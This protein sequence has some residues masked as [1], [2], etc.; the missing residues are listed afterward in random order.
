MIRRMNNIYYAID[1]FL[2]ASGLAPES[3]R[4]YRDILWKFAAQVD[5]LELD[6]VE[7]HHLNAF[8]AE[9]ATLS[10]STQ[11]LVVTVLKRFWE[12]LVDENIVEVSPAARLK[13]PRRP[14]PED[15]D[16]VTVSDSDVEKLIAACTTW[17]EFLCIAIL[18][19]LG[20]RRR[21]AS[22]LRRRHIDLDRREARFRE[23]G[24]KVIVKRI[25]PE[26]LQILTAAEEAGIWLSGDD[27]VIPNRRPAKNKE[28]SHKVIYDTVKKVAGRA[29]VTTHVHAL[30]AAFAVRFDEQ[31]PRE[32][33]ALKEWMGHSR[34]ETTMV[35]LRRKD[36]AQA[37][38]ATSE[39]SWNSRF[40]STPLVPP[41]GFEPALPP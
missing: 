19:Y 30:R 18:V 1:A 16:V 41:A 15:L 22:G 2:G 25:P 29:R 38:E 5:Q 3:I 4:K 34:F 20:V 37:M 39:L 8:K 9:Y 31:Y 6:Q 21:A 33:I 27:Y 13:R 40:P 17:Q 14:R 7:R 24:G 12:F 32:S 23:K 28:R 26:L 36:K 11:A 35:Y 10:P